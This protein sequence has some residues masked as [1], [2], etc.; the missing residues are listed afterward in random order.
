MKLLVDQNLS[1][2]LVASL[3]DVYPG[4]APIARTGLSRDRRK[5]VRDRGGLAQLRQAPPA[6]VAR[7]LQYPPA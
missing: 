4:S 3:A 2:R 7:A 5:S 6:L 1:P